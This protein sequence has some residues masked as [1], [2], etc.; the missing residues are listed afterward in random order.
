MLLAEDNVV[1]RTVGQLMITRA[2][3]LV[4]TVANGREAVDAVA[5]GNYDLVL[6]DVHMPELDGLEATM[7]IRDMGDRVHQPR[8]VALTASVTTQARTACAEA[9]MDDYLT[10]PLRPAELAAMLQTQQ[11]ATFLHH[12]ATSVAAETQ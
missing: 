10:K 12:A 6:M 11:A 1:N 2:G 8:I 4:D 9:G 5:R 7:R 3:H